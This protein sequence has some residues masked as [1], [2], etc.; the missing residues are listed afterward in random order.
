MIFKCRS[1]KST[2]NQEWKEIEADNWWDAAYVFADN[3]WTYSESYYPHTDSDG[4]VCSLKFGLVDIENMGLHIIREYHYG[5]RRKG[6]P[7]PQ[8]ILDQRLKEIAK[9]LNW[10]KDPKILLEVWDGEESYEEAIKR[11]N[12]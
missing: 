8:L 5:I 11:N 12:K 9:N 2:S 4:K 3:S 10:T 1:G 6:R 7:T